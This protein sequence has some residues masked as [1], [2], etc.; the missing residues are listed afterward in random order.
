MRQRPNIIIFNPDQWRGDVLGHMGNPA[1]LT[2]VLDAL[3][4][5]IDFPATV[6]A[7]TGITPRHHHFGCSLLP[8]LAGE[9]DVHRDAVF[10][11]GGRLG[12]EA[13]CSELASDP[14]LNPL[15]LY[16]CRLQMQVD[17][18]PAHT[19]AAMCRTKEYKYVR[20]LDEL[21]EL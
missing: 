1:A 12:E 4:E 7:M 18:W 9:T 15:G 10:C 3:V 17:G 16:Y 14:T 2:P 21:D 5:L 8:L 19:K 20:R 11:E 13:H 6:E